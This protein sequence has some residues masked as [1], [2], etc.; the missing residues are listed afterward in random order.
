MLNRTVL[1]A[2]VTLTPLTAQSDLV[3]LQ[4]H[5]VSDQ[6][7]PSTSTTV[8]LFRSH[9]S[10]IRELGLD[11]APLESAT[12][13]ALSG[14]LSDQEQVADGQRK[15]GPQDIEQLVGDPRAHGC[16]EGFEGLRVHQRLGVGG[17]LGEGLGGYG[18]T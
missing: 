10:R 17:H 3:V 4:Y 2:L 12:R 5:H 8:E 9:L 11:V 13:S 18:V 6:T 7:P 14:E 15:A 16:S 1:A